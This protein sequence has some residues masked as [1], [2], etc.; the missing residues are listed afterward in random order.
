MEQLD[1]LTAIIFLSAISMV[2]MIDIGVKQE[3]TNLTR[4]AV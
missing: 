2:R 3:V 1:I 4:S